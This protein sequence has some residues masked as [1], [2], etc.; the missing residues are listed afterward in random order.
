[1]NFK[2]NLI[3]KFWNH[4][5]RPASRKKRFSQNPA[6]T[7]SVWIISQS[8]IYFRNQNRYRKQVIR[9]LIILFIFV[10]LEASIIPE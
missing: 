3:K 8:F 7:Q 5:P 10:E 9:F 2:E 1:M 6:K 4:G